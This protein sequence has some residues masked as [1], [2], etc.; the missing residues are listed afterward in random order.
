MSMKSSLPK[1]PFKP[2]GMK[3]KRLVAIK[4]LYA[5]GVPWNHANAVI[6]NQ[7]SWNQ[8]KLIKQTATEFV[9]AVETVYE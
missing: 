4:T 6:R 2:C 5:N 8:P 9:P 3:L 1:N 7:L